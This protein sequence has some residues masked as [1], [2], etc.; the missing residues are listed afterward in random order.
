M[1]HKERRDENEKKFYRLTTD[2]DAHT[3]LKPLQLN[4]AFLDRNKSGESNYLLNKIE[5]KSSIICEKI[6]KLVTHWS[7]ASL[8]V[9]TTELQL[10]A[11][12]K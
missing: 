3:K 7:V 12:L 11:Q 6:A 10:I 4:G 1:L 2:K 9:V 8:L 5:Q